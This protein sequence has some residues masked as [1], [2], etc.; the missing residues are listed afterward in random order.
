MA[1]GDFDST[2]IDWLKNL[3]PVLPPVRSKTK[4]YANRTLYAR[5]SRASSKLQVIARSSDWFNVLFSP[6]VIAVWSE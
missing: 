4:A 6:V 1:V 5:F 2:L 3:A